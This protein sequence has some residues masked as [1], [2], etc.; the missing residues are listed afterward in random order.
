MYWVI[1]LLPTFSNPWT[2]ACQAPLSMGILE[3]RILEW[4]A[5]P[6]YRW[7]SQLRV[8]TQVIAGVFITVWA[9][10]KAQ[11][12][13]IQGMQGF[14]NICKSIN[15]I[16]HI[17]KLKD[18]NQMIISIL[19]PPDEKNWLIW[20]DPDAGKDWR[21][22]ERG[23]HR[24]TWLDGITDSKDMSLSKLQEMVKDREAWCAEVHGAAKSWTWLSDWTTTKSA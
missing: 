13:F 14:F 18:K 2:V 12:G 3:A 15:V 22:K 1:Q 5:I 20:K 11:V 24:M 6:S 19:W 17:N 9:T 8:Q 21:Q 23:W 7:S 16:H 10:G 4:V